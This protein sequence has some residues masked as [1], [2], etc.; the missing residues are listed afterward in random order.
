M[1]LLWKFTTSTNQMSSKIYKLLICG[2]KGHFA[3]VCLSKPQD[4][5]NQK[6]APSMH[7]PFLATITGPAPFSLRK[8]IQYLKT[9]GHKISTLIDSDSSE[10]F[11]HPDVVRN[12]QLPLQNVQT[13]FQWYQH[14]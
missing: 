2:K 11:I 5:T 12:Y 7:F 1:L 9:N 8:S 14:A 4:A 3:K 13:V 6:T 10:S